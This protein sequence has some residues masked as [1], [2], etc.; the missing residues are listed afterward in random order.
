MPPVRTPPNDPNPFDPATGGIGQSA[1]QAAQRPAQR[2]DA[3]AA[4][5]APRHVLRD[6]ADYIEWEEEQRLNIPRQLFPP[7]FDLQWVTQSV[8]NQPQLQ[9][10]S[11]FRRQGWVPVRQD[12]EIGERYRGMFMPHS[13]EGEI[14]V[15]GL[16]LMA[17]D[18]RWSDKAR[19]ID[20][21][22]AAERV[23][24]KE[25]QL[26]QGALT[27]VTLDPQHKTALASNV[28]ERSL[29]TIAIPLK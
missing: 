19:G 29:D 9:H 17:R 1:G 3:S 27:G 15:D 25:S 28:V 22:R 13:V 16:V 23:H 14:V 6:P 5:P 12:D 10:E 24:I 18:K 26:R 2:M 4:R 8:F 7:D 11:R 20:M 21:R